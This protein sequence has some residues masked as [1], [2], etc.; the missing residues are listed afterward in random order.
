M[1][2]SLNKVI[3]VGNLGKDPE[4]RV[5]GKSR[6]A[7]L[8]LATSRRRKNEEGQWVDE[9]DWHN[10]VYWISD[11]GTRPSDRAAERAKKGDKLCVEGSIVYRSYTDK[12]GQTRYATDITAR[13]LILLSGR[14]GEGEEGFAPGRAAS[15]SAASGKKEEGFGDFPEALD[16]EDDDLPF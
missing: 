14:G 13:D 5:A 4:I 9:A 11:I 6:V 7:T 15:S 1:S 2:Q 12:Q 16:A 10:V 3:L 8:R